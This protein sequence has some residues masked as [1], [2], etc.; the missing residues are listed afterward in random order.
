MPPAHTWLLAALAAAPALAQA[1][2]TTLSGRA[3]GVGPL[4][5]C[6]VRSKKKERGTCGGRRAILL[7]LRAAIPA[8]GWA[9]PGRL[10]PKDRANM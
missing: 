7:P 1:T 2:A 6:A 10:C 4:I 9:G 5:D 8:V 3:A